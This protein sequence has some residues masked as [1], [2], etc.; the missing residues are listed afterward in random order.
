MYYMD[1]KDIPNYNNNI[2]GAIFGHALGDAIAQSTKL[3]AHDTKVEFPRIGEVRSMSPNDWGY[4]TDHMM[5]CMQSLSTGESLSSLL[6]KYPSDVPASLELIIKLPNFTADAC[7]TANEI[8]EKSG[9]KFATSSAISRGIAC[10]ITP[11]FIENSIAYTAITHT[12]I[13]C[14]QACACVAII[15]RGLLAGATPSEIIANCVSVVTNEEIIACLNTER[16]LS[17]LELDKRPDYIIK[18]LSCAVYAL[19]I[20]KIANQKQKKPCIKKIAFKFAALRGHSDV[21]TGLVCAIIGAYIGV[22][23]IPEDLIDA[24]PRHE[25]LKRNLGMI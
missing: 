5:L 10:G 17:E 25:Q 23:A 24:M 18:A 8:W 20:I 19:N 11:N 3:C 9:R 6:V 1:T 15:I 2:A 12:D 16:T 14:K 13:R 22:D 21:N 4:A 7:G